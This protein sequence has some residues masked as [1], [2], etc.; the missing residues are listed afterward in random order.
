VD[1]RPTHTHTRTTEDTLAEFKTALTTDEAW[2]KFAPHEK[3]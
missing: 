2:G 3:N 1:H